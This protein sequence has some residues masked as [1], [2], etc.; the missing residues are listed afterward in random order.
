MRHE[1]KIKYLKMKKKGNIRKA[2]MPQW[3][4]KSMRDIKEKVDR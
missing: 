4:E 3:K 1:R 2:N